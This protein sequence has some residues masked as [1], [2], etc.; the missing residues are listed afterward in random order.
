VRSKNREKGL[1]VCHV[2]RFVLPSVRNNSA[3]TGQIFMKYIIPALFETLS[4]K[5]KFLL[6]MTR[7]TGTLCED[8]CT[9]MITPR[10]ILLK[11]ENI[12]DKYCRE[13]RD[14]NIWSTI[15]FSENHDVYDITWK[16]YGTPRQATADNIILWM[17][18]ACWITKATQT[19]TNKH[20]HKHTHTHTQNM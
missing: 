13:F 19:Q 16:K 5:F 3:L 4:R 9:F 17:H 2:C 8:L 14:K 11:M 20:T 18:D 15:F 1:L 10:W 7:I 6:N 12:W